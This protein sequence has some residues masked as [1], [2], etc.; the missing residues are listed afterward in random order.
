MHKQNS[1]A[2][3]HRALVGRFKQPHTNIFLILDA[4]SFMLTSASEL[5]EPTFCSVNNI[6][7]FLHLVFDLSQ[8][9]GCQIQAYKVFN[10]QCLY[11][12]KKMFE[13][14]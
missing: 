4:L 9:Q 2:V 7:I 11:P 8:P 10:D 6:Y 5:I 14:N 1:I 12:G 3:Q 13:S